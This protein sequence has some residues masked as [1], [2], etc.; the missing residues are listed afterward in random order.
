[1]PS[2]RISRRRLL[3]TGGSCLSAAVAGCSG[4]GGSTTESGTARDTGRPFESTHE[5]DELFVRSAD[6]EPFIHP[7]D[8]AAQREEE[9]DRPPRHT[10]SFFVI[11]EDGADSLRIDLEENAE[12]AAEI[13][14][15][16]ADTDFGTES[17][18]VDQRPIGDCYHRR[19]L[20]VRAMDDDFHRQYCRTLKDPMTPCEA[21]T[22]VMEAVVFRIRRPYEDAPSSHSSSESAS[23]RGPIIVGTN[24]SESD[25]NGTDAADSNA[26][27][28][29]DQNGTDGEGGD[30]E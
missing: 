16:V 28:P 18:V 8:A 9:Q 2:T 7:D 5:Y 25:S 10:R 17:I 30:R 15:F 14:E 21:D 1:M 20:S 11:D 12:A 4:T 19:V 3:A 29:R 23:C 13:R 24:G 22:D 27:E 6:D 26:T